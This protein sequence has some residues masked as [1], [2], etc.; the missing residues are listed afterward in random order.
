MV[1]NGRGEIALIRRG[2]APLYGHWMIPGGSLEWGETLEQAAVREVREETG[3]DIEVETF[4]DFVQAIAP[5]EPG[6][7]FLIMDYAAHATAGS[8]AAA[9]DAL[10]AEWVAVDSLAAYDLRPELLRVIHKARRLT[11]RTPARPGRESSS[12]G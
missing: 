11:R 2:K 10:E 8:L 6:Y 3:L 5:G 4:V 12:R 9:S 1:F 7:H